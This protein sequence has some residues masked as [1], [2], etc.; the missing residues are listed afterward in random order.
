MASGFLIQREDGAFLTH[1]RGWSWAPREGQQFFHGANVPTMH[2]PTRRT[3]AVLEPMGALGL[4][5]PW[6]HPNHAQEVAIRANLRRAMIR[7]RFDDHVWGCKWTEFW[8]NEVPNGPRAY[9]AALVVHLA[10]TAPEHR[11]WAQALVRAAQ[12]YLDANPGPAAPL[13]WLDIARTTF[14]FYKFRSECDPMFRGLCREDWGPLRPKHT[15]CAGQVGDWNWYIHVGWIEDPESD[16]M[17]A[18]APTPYERKRVVGPYNKNRWIG[19]D[20]WRVPTCLRYE[21]ET[22]KRVGE[23]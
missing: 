20:G 18:L 21:P 12:A 8:Y 22:L 15:H 13:A 10:D 3:L 14:D 11:P 2:C 19:L 5:L 17:V 7:H 9:C 4:L 6:D 16:R 23:T 1:N